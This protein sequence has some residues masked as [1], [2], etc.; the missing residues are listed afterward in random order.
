M[1]IT[2]YLGNVKIGGTVIRA[3]ADGSKHLDI[4]DGAPPS[5]ALANGISLYSVLGKFRVMDAAGSSIGFDGGGASCTFTLPNAATSITG[6]GTLGLGTF[7]LTVPESM[8]AAGRDVANTFTVN[9]TISNA[10]PALVFTDTTGGAKGLTIAVDANA[11]NIRE[12]AGASGSL[13][14]LDLTG[15]NVGIKTA[16][17]E[18]W[19]A[20]YGAIEFYQSAI[21][22]GLGNNLLD[23]MSNAYYDGAFKYKANGFATL[24]QSLTGGHTFKV[25]ASGLADAAITFID[26]LA[27]G[28]TGGVHVGGTSDPGDNNLL[29]DGT[30]ASASATHTAADAAVG[31]RVA[32]ATG[33]LR[34]IGYQDATYGVFID[35][36]N[37]AEG[38]YIPL[39]LYTTG[40]V[41]IP[42][43]G[44]HVG[45]TS[46]P[47]NDAL[48]VDG[49]FGC[50][51]ATAQT[52]YASGGAL[53]AYGAGANGLDSGANMSAL[54]AMVVKIR[55]AL[56]ANG[57]MS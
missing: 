53:A 50:N 33:K 23:I 57:I 56:V 7:T 37:A 29:V 18:A 47:G 9:Q 4:F 2:N 8:T 36:V 45:G 25:A 24:Y 49:K 52:A 6:G 44:L 26:A 16:D 51:G 39:S 27:V 34:I 42:G 11:A 31:L 17:I 12:S 43:G 14:F 38:A 13:L 3:G 19:Q 5:G 28:A 21:M 10:A 41:L 22:F 46:D 20:A 30:L 32:G 54:H 55:A 48:L 1:R 35:A 40:P 15:N